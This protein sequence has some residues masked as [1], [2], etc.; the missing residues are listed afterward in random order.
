MSEFFEDCWLTDVIYKVKGGKE[1]TVYCCKAH[2]STGVDFIAAKIYRP[3]M[4]RSMRNDA[5]YKEGRDMIDRA[6]K[7]IRDRRRNLAIRK[8]TRYGKRLDSVSWCLNEY[9]AMCML[10]EPG[11]DVVK[12]LAHSTNAILMEYIGE[13]GRAAQILQRVRLERDE[14]E[15]IFERLLMNVEKFLAHD[16]IHGDLSP[17]NVLYWME[18]FKIIDFPQTVKA[19]A[20]NNAFFLLSRDIE[21]ICRYFTRYGIASNPEDLAQNLWDRFM[22]AEL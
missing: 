7:A 8:K 6:G 14:A 20:N 21:R 10:H 5:I 9:K 16:R 17:Y 12:P 13:P 18:D 11:G 19:S 15:L 22:R 4:F 1:A 2:P 3:R